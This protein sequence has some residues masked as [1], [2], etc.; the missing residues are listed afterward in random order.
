MSL[1]EAVALVERVRD[2]AVEGARAGLDALAAAITVPITAVAIR[3]CPDIPSTIE[4]RIVDHRAQT[5]ADSVLYREAL[6]AAAQ[7]RG[8]VVHWYDR[9]R[10]R[11]EAATRLDREDLD[12]FL[13]AM[14]RAAGP[15]WRAQEKLAAM[16]AL[17]SARR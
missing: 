10:V 2:S 15:P 4:Q 16:A 3:A 5:V 7:E 1:A 9:E 12:V 13:N 11:S 6:A 8:W 14:G 17:A